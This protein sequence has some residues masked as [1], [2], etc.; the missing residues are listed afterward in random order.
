MPRANIL[1]L[2]LIA[3]P[4]VAAA[5]AP[6]TYDGL[7]AAG[8]KLYLD[9]DAA[10][11]LAKYEEAK[12]ADSG[13]PAAYYFVG[14]AKARLGNVEDAISSLGTAATL[15][16]DKDIAMHAKALFSIAVVYDDKGD[17][18]AAFTAWNKYLEYA[19]AHKD[20]AVFVDTAKSRIAVIERRRALETEGAAIRSRA[21]NKG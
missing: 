12:S 3:V 15:A 10:G 18:D 19:E 13:K 6:A 1:L 16:G 14:F 9:G 20:A 11:A 7:L 2:A 5:Q 17:W 8:H 21:E 4:A